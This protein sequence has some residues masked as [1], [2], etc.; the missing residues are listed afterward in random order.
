[1]PSRNGQL[2]KKYS[3]TRELILAVPDISDQIDYQLKVSALKNY[4]KDR[5]LAVAGLVAQRAIAKTLPKAL[6]AGDVTTVEQDGKYHIGQSHISIDCKTIARMRELAKIPERRFAEYC[7]PDTTKMPTRKGCVSWWSLQQRREE[8]AV[9]ESEI[10]DN[11]AHGDFP[12]VAAYFVPA[13]CN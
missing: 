1:M 12:S 11:V 10:P 4:A 3:T 7:D 5:D 2:T 9:E 8:S 13:V 6:K